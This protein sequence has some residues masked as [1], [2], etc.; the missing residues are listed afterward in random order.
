MHEKQRSD[1]KTTGAA[2]FNKNYSFLKTLFHN[3]KQEIYSVVREHS[4]SREFSFSRWFSK[5]P[6][7]KHIMTIT[8]P[9]NENIVEIQV[10]ESDLQVEQFSSLI[11]VIFML[12]MITSADKELQVLRGFQL[13][14]RFLN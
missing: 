3:R 9:R 5:Y 13:C 11:Q 4:I 6:L 10:L 2:S 1:S 12:S 8:S 14:F 7:P